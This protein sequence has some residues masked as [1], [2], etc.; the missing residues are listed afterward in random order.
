MI[1]RRD[2]LK[3]L[4]ASLSSAFVAACDPT[5]PTPTSTPTRVQPSATPQPTHTPTLTPTVTLTP[6][7]TPTLTPTPTATPTATPRAIDFVTTRGDQFYLRGERFPIRG[8]N[9]YPQRQPWKTFNLDAWDP[10]TVERELRLGASLGANVVRVFIDFHAS[11]TGVQTPMH[12]PSTVEPHA[13][14]I[15]N[16]REFLDIAARLNLK[17][18]LTLL[19]GLHFDMYRPENF[20]LIETY[21]RAIVPVFARDPRII[22]WDLQNEPDKAIRTVGDSIVIPFF[23]RVAQIVRAL[24]PLQLQTIGWI[25]RARAQ[26]FPALDPYLD[27]FCFHYYDTVDRLDSL[28]KFYKTQ[29]RKP[30]L[31]QEFGLPTG[32]PN[33]NFTENDQMIHYNAVM[34]ILR[35]NAMCGEVFW[36]LNDYP[37]G[38]AGNPPIPTDHRENHFGVFRLDYSEKPVTQVIRWYW[39]SMNQ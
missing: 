23:Q 9:Y 18:M 7:S 1:S 11:I 25:D 38:V 35:E 12:I 39:K 19:D 15:A 33:N 2:F 36:C 24:D 5:T 27:F 17:V 29:T 37:V 6:T 22:C 26:Y 16:V 34:K 4:A 31:L 28:C 13:R 10:V 30:V 20:A 21:L 14:Y 3:L 8:F 32:G